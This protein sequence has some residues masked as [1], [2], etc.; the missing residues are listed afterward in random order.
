[1]PRKPK[2]W[3]CSRCRRRLKHRPPPGRLLLGPTCWRILAGEQQTP[4]AAVPECDG[5]LALFETAAS[6]RR[7][8]TNPG[9]PMQPPTATTER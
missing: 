4:G 3:R 2:E 1:M 9:G 5:Q 6:G 7:R 8:S